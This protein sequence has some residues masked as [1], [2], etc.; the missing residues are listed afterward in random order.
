MVGAGLVLQVVVEPVWPAHHE[1]PWGQWSPLRG[2]ILPG[3]AIFVCEK[4]GG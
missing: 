4:P 2:R 1:R 3:T